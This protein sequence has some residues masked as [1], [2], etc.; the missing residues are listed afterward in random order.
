M[1]AGVSVRSSRHLLPSQPHPCL[2]LIADI[3]PHIAK[4][5]HSEAAAGN[6]RIGRDLISF[7]HA[8]KVTPIGL[9]TLLLVV[10]ILSVI[11]VASW[12]GGNG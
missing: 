10:G 9:A 2:A 7:H 11:P 3:H 8:D 12:S 1:A 6:I 5:I 4:G